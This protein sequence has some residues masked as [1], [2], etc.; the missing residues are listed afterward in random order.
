MFFISLLHF[1][2]RYSLPLLVLSDYDITEGLIVL[3]FCG[4]QVEARRPPLHGLIEVFPHAKCKVPGNT[5]NLKI[6]ILRGVKTDFVVSARFVNPTTVMSKIH[7]WKTP[8]IKC[9][10]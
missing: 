3:S 2:F 9:K 6:N 8:S 7:C 1:L 10:L 4:L 5:F